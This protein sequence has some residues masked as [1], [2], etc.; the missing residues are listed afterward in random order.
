MNKIKIMALVMVGAFFGVGSS[1]A[2]A[3]CFAMPH[4]ECLA[5]MKAVYDAQ[6]KICADSRD[7]V[8]KDV[9]GPIC[10]YDVS[11][12]LCGVCTAGAS[13]GYNSCVEAEDIIIL[14]AVQGCPTE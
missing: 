10:A 5:C 6:I 11:T 3:D 7:Q 4:Q 8:L 12:I 2:H 13:A 1:T 14:V 9:C